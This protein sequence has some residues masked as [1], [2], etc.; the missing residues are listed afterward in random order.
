[1]KP[2]H[3]SADISLGL[4]AGDMTRLAESAADA[5]SWG[6]SIFHFDVMDGVFVPQ[7]TAG[8]AALKGLGKWGRLDVHLMVARP[9]DHV[10]DFIEAGADLLTIHAEAEEPGNAFRL[11]REE[12]KARK[13]DLSVG[14][15][16]MPGTSLDEV[17][18]LWDLAPDIVLVL[19]LDP[20][21]GQ[22]ADISKATQRVAALKKRLPRAIIAFDGGVTGK[23]IPDIAAARP[24]LVVSGSAVMRAPDPAGAFQQMAAHLRAAH[25]GKHLTEEISNG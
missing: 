19:G 22:P 11:A 12:A 3:Q 4:F 10:V 16:L 7:L 8:A 20:R 14:F 15:A 25:Q 23:T 2:D 1:M 6:A 5:A 21:D 24:N 13:R 18:P 9:A 17:E